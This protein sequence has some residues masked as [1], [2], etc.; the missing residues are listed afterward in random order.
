[1]P[2]KK[3]EDNSGNVLNADF[4]L[5]I[6]SV[7]NLDFNR[8]SGHVIQSLGP[9]DYGDG[10]LFIEN[11]FKPKLRRGY[12]LKAIKIN[13]VEP[14]AA[15]VNVDERKRRVCSVCRIMPHACGQSFS[16]HSLAGAQAAAQKK[17]R[18]PIKP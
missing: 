7:K 15:I 12:P 4:A 5:G 9:L 13:M 18:A 14:Q 11:F 17:N 10:L 8:A 6:Q 16:Q 3:F 2:P 1:M